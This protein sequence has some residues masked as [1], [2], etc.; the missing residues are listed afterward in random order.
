MVRTLESLIQIV[1]VQILLSSML[2]SDNNNCFSQW[3]DH[4]TCPSQW[5]DH[6]HCP[7]NTEILSTKFKLIYDSK[8]RI[9]ISLWFPKGRRSLYYVQ[10]LLKSKD[11]IRLSSEICKQQ[12]LNEDDLVCRRKDGVYVVHQLALM[13]GGYLNTEISYSI[14]VRASYD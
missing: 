12:G 1:G 3:S 10:R 14:L 5:S 7:T 4:I 13:A 6:F 2:T 8:G 11:F 9:N